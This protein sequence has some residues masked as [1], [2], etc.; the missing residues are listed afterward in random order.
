VA[1]LSG[2]Y[3]QEAVPLRRLQDAQSA[4]RTAEAEVAAAGRR[5]GAL[6]GGGG[7]VPLV[8][9]ISGMIVSST[10][11]RGSA[12][13]AGTELL[14][15]GNPGQLWL[16]ARVPEALAAKVGTPTGLDL[17]RDG[18]PESLL[19]GPQLRLVQRGSFVDPR[20]RMMEVIFAG[21][22]G[23]RPGTRLAG[24]LRTGIAAE[25]LSVPA[26][27]VIDEGGQTIVYV[28]V[29]GET[30]ERRIVTIGARSGDRVG[31]SGDIKAGERVVTVGAA[32]VRAAAATPDAFGH[33]HAH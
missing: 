25:M 11:V 30:F 32:A 6:A 27:A 21:G 33:G 22:A 12:V 8:A 28:Q 20:T 19:V 14:R 4:L 23:L 13:Q 10:L 9:P 24:R 26:S 5:R 3:R 18:K 31:I 2:L 7:G 29:A 16:V 17:V 15:I 1:R